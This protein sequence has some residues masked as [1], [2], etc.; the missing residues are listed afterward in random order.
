MAVQLEGAV[1]IKIFRVG[2]YGGVSITIAGDLNDPNNDGKMRIK[3]IRSFDNP[4]CMFGLSGYLDFF[5]GAFVAG[6]PV[7]QDVPLRLRVLPQPEA[8]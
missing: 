1:S 3:E 6:G 4:M 7:H 8:P 5:L 2:V